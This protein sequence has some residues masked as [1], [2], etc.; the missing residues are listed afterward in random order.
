M[1]CRHMDGVNQT[2][3]SASHHRRKRSGPP[4]TSGRKTAPSGAVFICAYLEVAAGA[5]QDKDMAAKPKDSRPHVI[6][7][8]DEQFQRETLVDFL[9]AKGFRASG[10]DS[11]ATLRKLVEKDP[12]ALV[13]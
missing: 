4:N 13:L 12:P 5:R 1:G 7:V 8:E 6:V 9:D 3:A 10:V 2:P 11:G